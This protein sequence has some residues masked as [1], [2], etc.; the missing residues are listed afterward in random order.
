MKKPLLTGLIA[1]MGCAFTM[2]A[3]AQDRMLAFGYVTQNGKDF[4]VVVVQSGTQI[5]TMQLMI[6]PQDTV[7]NISYGLTNEAKPSVQALALMNGKSFFLKEA[8][9]NTY[10]Y[11]KDDH[12]IIGRF[13]KFTGNGKLVMDDRAPAIFE[14]RGIK[15]VL[16]G[17]QRLEK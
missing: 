4:P 12:A 17:A 13:E 2:P 7:H 8:G 10:P 11:M 1:A 14:E 16:F 15:F 3:L 9:T 5:D 6:S